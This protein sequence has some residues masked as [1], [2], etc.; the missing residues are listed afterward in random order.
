MTQGKYTYAFYPGISEDKL[1]GIIKDLLPPCYNDNGNGSGNTPVDDSGNSNGSGSDSGNA[2][3][4]SFNVYTCSAG[5]FGATQPV[6]AYQPA[7]TTPDENYLSSIDSGETCPSKTDC[8]FGFNDI[9]FDSL[10]EA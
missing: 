1:K 3:K 4:V 7:V 8:D 5:S 6:E 10:L 2:S 9:G